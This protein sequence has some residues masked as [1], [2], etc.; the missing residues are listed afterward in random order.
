MSRLVSSLFMPELCVYGAVCIH[1]DDP[2]LCEGGAQTETAG[3]GSEEQRE[4]YRHR[5]TEEQ[6]TYS[7]CGSCSSF[8]CR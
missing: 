8:I 5:Q 4:G 2:D 1:G 6:G 7:V 3:V